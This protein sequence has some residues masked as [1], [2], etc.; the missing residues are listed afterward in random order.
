MLLPPTLHALLY[1]TL[2]PRC[3]LLLLL[4]YGAGAR[5]DEAGDGG[6]FGDGGGAV[7]GCQVGG[8]RV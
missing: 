3:W 4:R 5:R 1:N 2:P 7:A 8:G 6:G